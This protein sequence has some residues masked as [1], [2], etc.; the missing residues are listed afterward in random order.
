[1]SLLAPV[2]LAFLGLGEGDAWPDY[3]G[4]HHDGR[5]TATGVIRNPGLPIEW[6]E[7]KNIR[8][9]T[10]IKLR[11]WS[12]P[13]AADNR[14]WLT[15]ATLDGRAF[16]GVCV[17]AMNGKVLW[18]E[19]LFE[20]ALPEP[21]GNVLNGYASPSPA[22]D[23]EHVYFH[24]GSYGTCCVDAKTCAVQWKRADLKCRHY[25]GPGSSVALF[26]NLVL[27][28]MDGIDVQYVVALDRDTGKTIWKTDRTAE[29]NDL[30]KSGRPKNDGDLRKSYSTALV[31]RHEGKDV[32]LSV[33]AKAI[34]G[35]DP[36]TGQELWKAP[37]LCQGCGARPVYDN[38]LAFFPTGF[39]NTEILAVRPGG[40]DDISKSHVVWRTVRGMPRLS[41]PV[42]VDGRLYANSD[43]GVVTCLDATSGDEIWKQRIGG[44]HA[45]SLLYGDGRLYAFSQ[46]GPASVFQAGPRFK[47]LATNK[48]DA[49]CMA[50][51]IALGKALIVRTK[52]HL[53]RIEA[54]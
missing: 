48:L 36:R 15:T 28:T 25:R 51:P 49:G 35:Y 29:W 54:D 3:R 30:D 37:H 8:W 4:P 27:L 34:Y 42:V 41:S 47:L 11:G 50:S 13:V 12:T 40:S 5:A 1:M 39:G 2:L 24:F 32:L 23:K 20:C 17:D 10:P 18:H 45:A 53:Y 33:G 19:R 26:E 22:V 14:I 44:E 46:N 31:V 7:A 38:G 21:L 43:V 16:F 6:N 52:S 9:K